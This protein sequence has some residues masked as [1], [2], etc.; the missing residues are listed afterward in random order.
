MLVYETRAPLRSPESL[1]VLYLARSEVLAR[2]RL[3]SVGGR[4]SL[5]RYYRC[6]IVNNVPLGRSRVYICARVAGSTSPPG[7]GAG[8][9]RGGGH[10]PFRSLSP[11]APS[12]EPFRKRWPLFTVE[13]SFFAPV[14]PRTPS[15]HTLTGGGGLTIRLPAPLSSVLLGTTAAGV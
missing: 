13:Y 3:R 11:R 7:P 14:Q 5:D 8:E 2:R 10:L 9:T 12:R 6:N 15:V 1:D 4:W